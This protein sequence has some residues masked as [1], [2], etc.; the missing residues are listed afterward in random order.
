MRTAAP[1][2]AGVATP[3]TPSL[4][5]APP[6]DFRIC[7][8]LDLR[9]VTVSKLFDEGSP[10]IGERRGGPPR[11]DFG[12]PGQMHPGPPAVR[13]KVEDLLAE[14]PGSYRHHGHTGERVASCHLARQLC[15]QFGACRGPSNVAPEV[16]Q[17]RQIRL[18]LHRL[19]IATRRVIRPTLPRSAR[20][21][22]RTGSAPTNWSPVFPVRATAPLASR[23]SLRR[24]AAGCRRSRR[25]AHT[26][27][28]GMLSPP[29]AVSPERGSLKRQGRDAAARQR[30]QR[31]S[32]RPPRPRT[33]VPARRDARD[34]WPTPRALS[35][36]SCGPL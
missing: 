35:P 7:R 36:W 25:S 1:G 2:R 12:P 14:L 24:L 17:L 23:G 19:I 21:I 6:A 20:S 26:H 15:F 3:H 29:P 33:P 18:V 4:S 34:P 11:I 10:R 30:R 13:Q 9:T 16:R 32:E 5:S 31:H 8:E 22:L 27:A 28:D